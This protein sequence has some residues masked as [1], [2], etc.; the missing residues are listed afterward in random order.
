MRI[1]I[2]G[3]TGAGQSTR[4]KDAI[5]AGFNH[6]AHNETVA[7]GLENEEPFL[8]CHVPAVGIETEKQEQD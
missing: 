4:G 3:N 5:L 6:S 7:A 8:F 2:G 1:C